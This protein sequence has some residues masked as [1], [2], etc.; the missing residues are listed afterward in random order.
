MQFS[1]LAGAIAGKKV[2]SVFSAGER[3]D[4]RL[5]N[6]IWLIGIFS[7]LL[8][9]AV[10]TLLGERESELTSQ[11]T[12]RT[13]TRALQIAEMLSLLQDAETGERGYLLTGDTTYLEPYNAALP[14]I[15]EFRRLLQPANNPGPLV[16]DRSRLLDGLIS[17]RLDILAREIELERRGQQAEALALEKAGSGKAIM[18][19]IR[20]AVRDINTVRSGLLQRQIEH[21]NFIRIVVRIIRQLG[22]FFLIVAGIVVWRQTKLTMAAQRRARDEAMSANRA[23]SSFLA[24][25]SHELRTPMT[26]I[27]GMADLLLGD[28]QPAGQRQITQM[29]ANAAHSLLSLL[30]DI[31]DLS[32]IETGKLALQ[33][34]D[35][36]VSD[37]FQEVRT[38]LGPVASRKGLFIDVD[39]GRGPHDV[40]KGDGKR[41]Q[42]IV[43]NLI[44]N[45][46]KFTSSGTITVTRSFRAVEADRVILRVDVCDTG[47]GI[48][49][50]AQNRLFRDFQQAD[51]SI[52]AKYGG[53]GL[54]L[55]I[56]HKI[57]TAMGGTIGLDS[58]LGKGSR[59][60]FE[61]PFQPGKENSVKPA[62]S[63]SAKDAAGL[64][65]GTTYNILV[66]DDTE[67][68]RFLV[69]RMLSSWGH[70]VAGASNGEE[71]VRAASQRHWD[72][73]LM[74]MQMP[75]MDGIE[76]TRRIRGF[77]T[78]A[79]KVPII[80]VTADA[81]QEHQGEYIAAGCDAVVL[82]PIDWGVLAEQMKRLAG[83]GSFRN[84]PDGPFQESAIPPEHEPLSSAEQVITQLR[85]AIGAAAVGKLGTAALED[86]ACSITEMRAALANADMGATRRAGHRLSGVASQFGA[87]ETARIAKLIEQK[88]ETISEVENLFGD[89]EVSVAD[90]TESIRECIV[91]GVDAA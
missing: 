42:Q 87:F 91:A 34:A 9:I 6:P 7:I 90:E 12:L 49:D 1:R 36:R 52:S 74:D 54:G 16:R 69:T 31:L 30:N 23:K 45:A 2:A 85:E 61:I 39:P 50:E 89:L 33:V 17:R 86:I 47:I 81:V 77:A 44:G 72:L 88:A 25:M 8:L 3:A 66:V 35:F 75:I 18:D 73:I 4:T 11:L 62:T 19:R 59:F 67:A 26:A 41:F 21:G 29:L 51:P 32:K 14:Q 53:T 15:A 56:C 10:A 48:S 71:A 43:M 22:F 80:A 38:L 13:E 58:E 83:G 60:Y 46:I 28:Q 68:T 37:V 76:A 65:A 82:K 40:V 63:G 20:I 24:N 27:I 84:V 70:T 57:V 78:S 79:Q 64:L 5:F 55:S